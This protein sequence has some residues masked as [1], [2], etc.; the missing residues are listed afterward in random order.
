MKVRD[1]TLLISGVTLI[2]L[3]GLIFVVSQYILA[4][5]VAAGEEA[6]ARQNIG[7]TTDILNYEIANVDRD[8]RDWATWDDTYAFIE[9]RNEDYIRSNLVDRTFSNLNLN[10][11]LYFNSSGELV[12]GKALDWRHGRELPIPANLQSSLS[13]DNLLLQH[14]SVDANVTGILA[15][16]EDSYLIAARP[17]VTSQR[18]GPIRGTLV[19]GRALD[20]DEI[21]LLAQLTHSSISLYRV[22]DPQ[23]PASVQSLWA[24]TAPRPFLFERPNEQTIVAYAPLRDIYGNP[25]LVLR[26]QDTRDSYLQA[27][28]ALRYFLAALLALGLLFGLL[29]Y[30]VLDRL[31]LSRLGRLSAD[32]RTLGARGDLAARV[33]AKGQDELGSLADSINGMLAALERAQEQR[34]ESEQRYRALVEQA[35]EGIVLFDAETKQVL[36]ANPAYQKLVGY[37]A[38]ELRGMTL[39]DLAAHDRESIERNVAVTLA[40]GSMTVGERQHRRRDGFLVSLEINAYVISLGGCR[41]VCSMT[42]DITERKWA[43]EA[44]R[45]NE[46]HFRA[47]IDNSLDPLGI[48][49]A[50]GTIVSM[51][52]A[53]EGV[54]G[55]KVEDVIGTNVFDYIHP[56]DIPR[57]LSVFAEALRTP[58]YAA[59]LECR[60]KHQSGSWHTA[61]V[62][63]KNLLNNP[64][65]VGLVY[66][67][68]DITERKQAEAALRESEAK[69]HALVEQA[70][71]ITYI[72]HVDGTPAMLYVSPQVEQI[73][74]FTPA[75][76]SAN[77][78]LWLEQLHPDDRARVLAEHERSQARGEP[79]H[80]EYRM[81][82]RDGH[83]VWLRDEARVLRDAADSS[84]HLEGVMVDI[85]DRKRAEQAL[86]ESEERYRTVLEQS[87][88]AIYLYD[89]ESRHLLEA[90]PAF[91]KLL[92]YTAEEV[93][94]L[95]LYDVV[96]D[97][98]AGIDLRWGRILATGPASLGERNWRRKDGG[99]IAVEVTANRMQQGGKEMIFFVA[100]DITQRKQMEAA[101]REKIAALQTLAEINRELLDAA[102]PETILELVCRRAAELSHA[103]KSLI[104]MLPGPGAGRVIASY[105]LLDEAATAE[106]YMQRWNQGSFHQGKRKVDAAFGVDEIAPASPHMP[107]FQRREG[108][109]SLA[110][111][112]LRHGPAQLG[113]MLVLDTV[114][115]KWSTDEI[116][117]LDLLAQ[118]AV[119]ILNKV[120]LL[121]ETQ[122]RAD[123]F[124][125]LYETAQELATPRDLPAL[126]Q[127][128][129]EHATKLLNISGGGGLWLYDA[130]RG[131]LEC[132]V[133]THPAISVGFRR[134]LG[135]GVSGRIAATRQPLIVNDYQTWQSNAPKHEGFPLMAAV[136]VPI[137]YGGELMGVLL[138]NELDRHAQSPGVPP[139]QFTEEDARLLSLFAGQ[140]ASAVRA[141]Q[142]FDEMSTRVQQLALLYDAGLALNRALAPREQLQFL[143]QIALKALR[144]EGVTFFSY[145]RV[146]N[147]L[148]L[149]L[150]VGHHSD[151]DLPRKDL[152]FKFGEERGLVGWVAAQRLPLNLGDVSADPRWLPLDPAIRSA[153][154]AP[155]E[156]DGH[157]L[158]VMGVVCTSTNAFAPQD[159]RLLVL[160]SNQVAVA[161]EN[162]R[163][164]EETRRG[165]EQLAVLNRIATAINQ[166]F[167]LSEL[168]EVVYREVT[169]ALHADSGF[170]AL[171]DPQTDMVDFSIR[172]DRG[173][174]D[175][176][177]RESLQDCPLV[178]HIIATRDT[179]L[180]TDSQ[181]EAERFP[182]LVPWGTMEP[183]RSWLG[184]PMRIGDNVVGVVALQAYVANAFGE[185]EAQLLATI[186][187]QLAVAMEK[188]KLFEET[189]QR[190]A[191]MEA[192]NQISTAL[193]VAQSHDEML[194]VLLDQTLAALETTTGFIALHDT[195]GPMPGHA[196]TR[197]WL[198]PSQLA[199]LS[200]PEVMG[201]LKNLQKPYASREFASDPRIPEPM[202][203]HILAGWGGAVAPIRTSQQLIGCL[204]V[205]V[206]LP[207]EL[208]PNEINLLS[209]VSEIAGNA[210]H[211]ATLHEETERR[212]QRLDALRTIDLAISGS[213]NLRIT[214]NIFL[215]QVMV[216]LGADAADIL[217]LRP[218]SQHLEYAAGRGFHTAARQHLQLRLGS[219]YAGRAALE[220][221]AVIISDLSSG[222][223]GWESGV[224]QS[225]IASLKAEGFVSYY[226]LPLVAKGQIRGALEVLQRSAVQRSGEWLDFMQT[227]AGQAAIAIENAE[228]L[229]NL[230]RSNAD[231]TLAYEATIEGWAHA[232]ELRDQEARGHTRRVTEMTLNLARALGVDDVELAHIRHGALLHDIG[233][234]AISDAILLKPGPLSSEEW[235]AMHRHPVYAY[236]LLSRIQY[237]HPALDIPYCHHEKWDGTGYPRGLQ[238]EQIPLAARIFAVADVWDALRSDRPDRAA[239]SAAQ[240]RAHL[241]AEAGKH[242]DPKVVQVFLRMIGDE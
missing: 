210:I 228:L 5:Y 70:P 138:V 42:R 218:Q 121:A 168:L 63:G 25:A 229:E 111:V 139:R 28:M 129:T 209:T 171:Y 56:D 3:L 40:Q 185:E 33:Q 234:M 102:E 91:L 180:L 197:G 22:A 9:N 105:G 37:S 177:S 230:A 114:P 184:V 59:T 194:P 151:M 178:A 137:L 191:A 109:R 83:S 174:R 159:E 110:L 78:Q 219:G 214:L 87:L 207:R 148:R 30:G 164:F 65:V 100:R 47:L 187:D 156:H 198:T 20:A 113:W 120:R 183:S 39:Y 88:E 31:I 155:V 69:Y 32:V 17:I 125:A 133:S 160:F 188:G 158:G 18:Q 143:L 166:T 233:K 213:L 36:E 211:R 99:V 130:A 118:Q 6:D 50:D 51:S 27:Q 134:R 144:A 54:L 205:A 116:Q 153:L 49:N 58:D 15:T 11:I 196:V 190:L 154:W 67:F 131:E 195:S 115:R 4:G 75:E 149:E 12:F 235:A 237:L 108:V 41:V 93:S 46:E 94:S 150:G 217:L 14:P 206:P 60:L 122:H 172:T 92:G 216:Q 127:T 119:L 220:Q 222:L 23:L 89:A 80:A 38:E 90:N 21:A 79:F 44:L 76:Y 117:L 193:R 182:N 232:L 62:A 169:A 242:F 192:V 107:Q 97:D 170:I 236:E 186:A 85:T 29:Y 101:L 112:P 16:P 201:R 176:V 135:E 84:S 24:S 225:E 202:R 215:E 132:V 241:A 175:P 199:I 53:I 106:E 96:V 61:E 86:R 147:E 104:G 1:K 26:N 77:P 10:L 145:D 13:P 73:L 43:Q 146:Q 208:K 8:V 124:A 173:L 2:A 72:A 142:L 239:W 55:Y 167:A 227:L 52:P 98:R 126:L 165:A 136:G 103:P 212:L 157:L 163:L 81:R 71:A 181:Q 57:V 48:M 45:H 152:T 204:G 203:T 226:A 179:L 19:M 240:A 200:R 189:R 141:A 123:E 64:A 161:L 238:G 221:Q 224:Q 66:N 7:R 231:L 35:S 74:G 162:A 223:A 128:I 68:R 95:T 140:A 34:L 82:A